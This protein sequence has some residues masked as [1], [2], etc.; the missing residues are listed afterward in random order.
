MDRLANVQRFLAELRPYPLQGVPF[1]WDIAVAWAATLMAEH[2]WQAAV[3]TVAIS[4]AAIV[5]AFLGGGMMA[6][7]AARS[8]ATGAPFV[9][10]ENTRGGRR[11]ML[12]R[13]L[14]TTA[15]LALIF[16]R[17]IPEYVWAFL[18]LALLGPS[19]WP[20]VLA[21]AL[22]NGGILGKLSAEVIEDL[23]PTVLRAMAAAGATR[24]QIVVAG[25]LPLALPRLLLFFFYRWETCVRE[26]TVL[27]MLGIGSLGY[28]IMDARARNF[29][30]EM[31]FFVLIGALLV[32]LGDLLSALAREAV[33]RAS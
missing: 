32:M 20:L 15:R 25:A 5:L 1:D 7:P 16:L 4:V 29:Y 6:V 9:L 31:L 22:H 27:G 33:R 21:L 18:L 12:W 30:D 28:W 8:F 24:L 26:A 14:A 23:P 17:A 10:G 19:S 13:A 2:G 3:S 11:E